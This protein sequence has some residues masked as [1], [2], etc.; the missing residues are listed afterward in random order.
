MQKV[1]IKEALLVKVQKDVTIYPL[2]FQNDFVQWHHDGKLKF[3]YPHILT[4]NGLEFANKLLKTKDK[5]EHKH[6]KS[7]FSKIV[8]II[9]RLSPLCRKPTVW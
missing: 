8:L 6:K 1:S 7:D 2:W 5:K 4:D 9:E 3:T